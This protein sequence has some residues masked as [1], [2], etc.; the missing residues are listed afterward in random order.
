MSE[1]LAVPSERLPRCAVHASAPAVTTCRGCALFLCGECGPGE[2]PRCARCR[3]ADHPI[4]WEDPARARPRAFAATARAALLATDRFFAAAPWTGGLRAPLSFA[5][6][7][8][9]LAT[10]L[11]T[12]LQLAQG[13]LLGPL[14]RELSTSLAAR[15]QAPALARTLAALP[16]ALEQLSGLLLPLLLARLALTPLSAALGLLV[17]AALSHPIAR[18]LGGHGSFEATFRVLAYAGAAQLIAV[19]PGIGVVLALVA[20][21]VLTTVGMRRAHGLSAGR[22]LVVAGW[23]IPVSIAGLVLLA[24]LVGVAFASAL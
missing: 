18:W 24:A 3:G 22:A 7:A 19:I 23:W 15:A 21:L 13:A 11:Q 10:A 4:P 16:G 14:L 12:A 1:A 2:A 20:G 6:V 17:L 8:A 5:V 9:T